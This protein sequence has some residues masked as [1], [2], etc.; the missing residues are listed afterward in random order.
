M[1]LVASAGAA[2]GQAAGQD[3]VGGVSAKCG[4]TR[5]AA[6]QELPATQGTVRWPGARGG[7]PDVSRGSPVHA[8]RLLAEQEL[9][10]EASGKEHK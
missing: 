9:E 10:A 7:G 5:A 6:T 1:G 2:G 4:R 8:G 3:S